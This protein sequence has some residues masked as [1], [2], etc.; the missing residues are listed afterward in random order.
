MKKVDK[1]LDELLGYIFN[2]DIQR[3]ID[4]YRYLDL[5]FFSRLDS[6]FHRT[7]KK[8]E[9]CLLRHYLVYG[10]FNIYIYII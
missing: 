5:R 8:F 9:L 2:S 3:L 4:Y 7:V 1:I 6:R 10:Q